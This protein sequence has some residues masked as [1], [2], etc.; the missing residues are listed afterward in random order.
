MAV[1]LGALFAYTFFPI[2][3]WMQKK[4]KNKTAAALLVCLIF[5]VIVIVPGV[6]IIKSLVSES[7]IFYITVKQKLSV[8][9]FTN[10]ENQVCHWFESLGSN[11]ELSYQIQQATKD[12]TNWIINRGSN[13]LV[14]IPKFILNIFVMLFTMYYFLKEGKYV[15]KSANRYLCMSQKKFNLIIRRLKEIISGVVYGYLLIALIQ[16]SLGALGF[17]IFGISSPIFWGVLIGLFALIPLLGTGIIWVPASILLILEGIFENSN[18]LIFK[19]IG[20]FIYCAI[21]V[22][23]LDNFIRPKLVGDRAKVHP[24]L[25][26]LGIFGGIT[27]FGTLGV[28]IGPLILSMTLVI[29]NIYFNK[30]FD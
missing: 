6:F 25:I 21:F 4:V 11:Q 5:L 24:A 16:G 14:S 1:F 27:V 2:Y 12:L 22:A 15:I 3:N 26:L 17:F 29:L 10:C 9:F 23:S 8:G 20:L 19:G 30:D 13:I 28:I 18:S 7:Y